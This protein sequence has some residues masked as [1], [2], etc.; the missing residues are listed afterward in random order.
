VRFD[1]GNSLLKEWKFD[2]SLDELLFQLKNDAVI[3]R[4]WS[5]S[6]A[7]EKIKSGAV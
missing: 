7:R 3:G 2:K 5:A 6:W 1:E 4:M